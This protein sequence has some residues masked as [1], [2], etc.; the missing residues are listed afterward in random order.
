MT[1]LS[2]LLT[3]ISLP[4]YAVLGEVG[5]FFGNETVSTVVDLSSMS[6]TARSLSADAYC[7]YKTYLT[8]TYTGMSSGFTPVYSIE[9]NDHDTHGY[10][11]YKA[12]EG[13]IY[14]VYRGSQTIKNWIDNLNAIL[15]DYPFC[16]KCEVHQG[17]YN[18]HQVVI[19]D[20]RNKVN[21]LRSK[22]P[23]Y[24]VIISGHSLGAALATL[25]AIDL[26]NSGIPLTLSHFGSPRVGN[27]EFAAFA[28]SFVA[29]RERVTHYK[30]MVPHCPMNQRFTHISGEWY[31]DKDGSIRACSGYEDETCSYQWHI[32]SI[33]DHMWYLGSY[34]SCNSIPS[35]VSL[36]EPEANQESQVEANATAA[37]GSSSNV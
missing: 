25:T 28:S 4:L 23:S 33:D 35:A 12:S 37:T 26:K 22:Y 18:A 7:D 8:R 5:S 2:V 31:E 14:V 32:T 16:S 34:M 20:V 19:E 36:D 24:K 10:I 11:G 21:A 27:D 9:D 15:T 30:D 17:F 1:K 3:A 13:N 29:T 6:Y